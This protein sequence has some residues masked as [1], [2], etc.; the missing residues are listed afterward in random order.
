MQAA[1]DARWGELL[2]I[3]ASQDI[4]ALLAAA[5]HAALDPAVAAAAGAGLGAGGLASA[6]PPLLQQ[7]PYP[8]QPPLGQ[9]PA[10]LAPLTPAPALAAPAPAVGD[11]ESDMAAFLAGAFVLGAIPETPPP[12]SVCSR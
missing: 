5:G 10:A 4:G 3:N 12:L 2:R 1:L 7:Q 8:P 6:A 11:A 9:P